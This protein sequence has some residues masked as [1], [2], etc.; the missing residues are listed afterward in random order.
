MEANEKAASNHRECVVSC[1]EG[2]ARAGI[3]AVCTRWSVF[4]MAV[5]RLVLCLGAALALHF[6]VVSAAAAADTAETTPHTNTWA[7]LVD[8]SRF[9]FNYRWG[10]RCCAEL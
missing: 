10:A 5:S 6:V 8:T 9:W 2:R 4:G 3:E 1:V 7:V